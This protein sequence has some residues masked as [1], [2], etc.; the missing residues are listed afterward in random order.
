[1]QY[2]DHC[3]SLAVVHCAGRQDFKYCLHPRFS[4][5][6]KYCNTL[7]MNIE[8]QILKTVDALYSVKSYQCNKIIALHHNIVLHSKYIPTQLTPLCSSSSRPSCEPSSYFMYRY[9]SLSCFICP[10]YLLINR[11]ALHCRP[12]ME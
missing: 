6:F 8:I 1:M 7:T 11:P 2:S 12:A 4:Q 10:C 3:L 9:Y 5:H